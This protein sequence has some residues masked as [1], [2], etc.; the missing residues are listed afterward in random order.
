M[1]TEHYRV[2]ALGNTLAWVPTLDGLAPPPALGGVVRGHKVRLAL[3]L[4][5]PRSI[6][7]DR[8]RFCSLLLPA[9]PARCDLS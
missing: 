1:A 4:D 5:Q 3:L 2:V 9:L 7:L 6:L 8:G